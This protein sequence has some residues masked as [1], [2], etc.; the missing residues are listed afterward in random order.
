MTSA[1]T[2]SRT[3]EL[4]AANNNFG[5]AEGQVTLLK[6]GKVPSIADN[7]GRIA[8]DDSGYKVQTK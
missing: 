7:E 3:R 6:Q 2:D 5:M 4:L 1:D 8:L